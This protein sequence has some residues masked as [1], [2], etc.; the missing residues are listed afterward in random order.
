MEPRSP[1]NRKKQNQYVKLRLY[2]SVGDYLAKARKKAEFTQREVSLALGYSSA[3]YISNF[4]RG[5][6]IPTLKKLKRM[7]RLYRM[8]VEELVAVVIAAK[9][10]YL[11]IQLSPES[12]QGF[13]APDE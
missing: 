2:K 5:M 8:N 11:A 4:E 7:Q 13:G 12:K 6:A 3:Q 9:R 10:E 1:R